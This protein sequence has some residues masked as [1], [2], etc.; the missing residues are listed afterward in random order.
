MSELHHALGDISRI[1]RQMAASTQF[2]GYGPA[3]LA[4]TG[5]AAILAALLQSLLLPA[6]AANPR[7]Y[8]ELWIA[9]ATLGAS[10]AGWQIHRRTRRLHSSLSNAMLRTAIEQFLPAVA[11]G[12]LLT[13]V[14]VRRV[15]S[16]FP[17]VPGLW[18]ILYALGVFASCRFL[19]RPMVAAGAWYMLTGLCTVSL[20]DAR[21][22]APWTMGLAFGI[23]QLLIAAILLLATPAEE[24]S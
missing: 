3:T 4:L 8:L 16:S 10:F 1:R 22:L 2:R 15:P 12:L 11:A 19:P 23:G 5:A 24:Q 6:P 9:T 7:G 13:I 14:L 18:Q 20:G 21:A 17:L